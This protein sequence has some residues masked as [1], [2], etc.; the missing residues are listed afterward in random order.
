MAAAALILVASQTAL[1]RSLLGLFFGLSTALLLVASAWQR[2][3]VARLRGTSRVL[4]VGAMSGQEIAEI[5]IARGRRAVW[6][7]AVDIARFA[8]RLRVEADRR[9]HDAPATVAP[10]DVHGLIELAAAHGVTALVPL[11]RAAV[12]PTWARTCRR[13]ACRRSGARRCWC[14]R[15]RSPRAAAVL[16]KTLADRLLA[17]ALLIVLAPVLAAIAVAVRLRL[18]SPGAVHAAPGRVSRAAVLDVQVSNDARRRRG[19]AAGV[20]RAQPD[21]RS[22]VQAGRR[23]ARDA[24]RAVPAPQQPRRAAAAP[25][26]A[27]GPHEPGRAAPAAAGRDGTAA[28]R[29]PAAPLDAP[30]TDLPLASRAGE[31]TCRSASGWRWTWTTST[32]GAWA[33]TRQSCCARSRRSSRAAAR[34]DVASAAAAPLSTSA[35]KRSSKAARSKRRAA[36]R[37]GAESNGRRLQPIDAAAS[38]SGVALVEQH[39]GAAAVDGVGARRPAAKVTTGRPAASASRGTMPKSSSAG[40]I[41]RAAAA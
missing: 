28:R 40:W 26:R 29:P 30:R 11:S 17:A 8:A 18:G 14:T 22:R 21:G 15:A 9:D 20:A 36:A 35:A 39:A 2:R 33:W 41:T 37:N 38:D 10:A 1:N 4:I 16:V 25:Q 24:A 23:P 27:R 13:R 3:F 7:P 12:D 34:A 6:E 19:R 31:T 32:A 5:E